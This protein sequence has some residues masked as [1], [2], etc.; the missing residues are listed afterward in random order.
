MKQKSQIYCIPLCLQVVDIA[1]FQ[2]GLEKVVE[3]YGVFANGTY[4]GRISRPLKGGDWLVCIANS[5]SN[6]KKVRKRTRRGALL[7][8]FSMAIDR[9]LT[10]N[11]E[12]VKEKKQ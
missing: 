12:D 4:L 5:P 7:E 6:P 1:S 3:S 2:H 11:A 10:T 8:L 9:N